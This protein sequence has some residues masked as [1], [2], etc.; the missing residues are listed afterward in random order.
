MCTDNW[1]TAA[2]GLRPPPALPF[3]H[4]LPEEVIGHVCFPE[5]KGC[6]TQHSGI[7]NGVTDTGGEEEDEGRMRKAQYDNGVHPNH[8]WVRVRA[9]PCS[10]TPYLLWYVSI[11]YACLDKENKVPSKNHQSI[12]YLPIYRWCSPI[13]CLFRCFLLCFHPFALTASQRW[14]I[15]S[16]PLGEVLNWSRTV[17]MSE[18]D[19]GT[20]F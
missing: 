9:A 15:W 19:R 18:P 13:S 8:L 7:C 14:S 16:P 20:C 1:A 10:V 5:I 4:R 2:P 6:S 3:P 17:T 11:T 12:V